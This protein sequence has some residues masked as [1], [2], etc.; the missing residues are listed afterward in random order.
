MLRRVLGPAPRRLLVLL[1]PLVAIV[2]ALL[3][4]VAGSMET[5]SAGRAYVG[6]EGL[7]S[8]AQKD[9]VSYLLRYART[10]DEDDY[11]RYREAI[12]VPLGDRKAREAL[13]LPQP[14]YAAARLGF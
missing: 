14:D 2:A 3:V 6:G 8:K 1:L 13:E 9:A 11:L 4:L 12:A 5:L 7:W 10:F